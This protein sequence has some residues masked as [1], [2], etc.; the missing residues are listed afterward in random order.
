M[1]DLK[2]RKLLKSIATGGGVALVGKSLP[3]QWTR[4]MVDSVLLPAHA[5]TS[6]TPCLVAETYCAGSGQ[7]S[8][9]VAVSVDGSVTVTHNL[10]AET[11]MVDPCAGGSFLVTFTS[12][13][14]G[15]VTVSGTIPCGVVA[16]IEVIEDDGSGP[17]TL[18]LTPGNCP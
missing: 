13:G 6:C 9:S 1:S 3:D 4:P 7:S 10:G 5:A 8:I 11:V 14:G 16:S 15:T 18:T 12:Q 2:R 17:R